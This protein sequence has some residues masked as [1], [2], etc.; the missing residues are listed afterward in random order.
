MAGFSENCDTN[1]VITTP[2]HQNIN[3]FKLGM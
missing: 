1:N 2:E 3:L